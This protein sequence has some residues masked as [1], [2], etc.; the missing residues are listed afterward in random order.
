MALA[1]ALLVVSG[2]LMHMLGS[3][4]NTELGFSPDHILTG[5]IDLSPGR[6]DGRDV[7]ADF[8]QPLFDK[9]HAIP[10]VQAVGMI[11][12]LPIQNCGWNSDTRVIGT[13][14]PPPNTEQLAEYRVVSPG[15]FA[16]FED[17]LVSGRLLDPS[18]DTPTSKAVVVVN[19]AFVK[20][21]IPEGRDPI[22]MQIDNDDK[23]MIVG[24]VKNI[25]Q[26]IYQPPMAETDYIS[27]QVPKNESLRVLGNT[28]LVIRTG[29]DP[30][31]IVPS[32]RRAFH[33]VDPTLPFRTPETM[34]S[35]IGD[36]LIFERLENWLFGAFAALA[37]LLAIVGLYGLISHE[38]ELSTRDIGVRMA[39][40]ATRGR[41]L[42]GIYRRVGWMLSVGAVIGLLLTVVAKKY[43]SSVVALHLEKDAGR[44]L[45]LTVALVGAGLVAAFF[46]AR[47]ASSIEPVV[48][49]RDE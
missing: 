7:M 44:I 20:K 33:D 16:A 43:I 27:S 34:Q 45:I 17:R 21:F 25:R 39:L 40:G 32:L 48:A 9:I 5:E 15:Y 13:P 3:L 31:S 30:E 11:Q 35:V 28:N 12:V 1:L 22:G 23:T 24:V 4:R 41:I 26:N 10:G 14:P 49:L 37:V 19:E 2:L 38:V 8:Y 46:P 36:T 29:V 6:Y 42:T 47:R 18:L